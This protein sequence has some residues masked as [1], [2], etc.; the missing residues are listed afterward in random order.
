MK[1]LSL[2]AHFDGEQIRLDDPFPIE[3]D[4]PLIVTVWQKERVDDEEEALAL[5]AGSALVGA[6][7]EEPEY[8]LDLI[9]EPNP[10]YEVG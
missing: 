2:R 8:S 9:K 7:V 10:G 6:S 5:L 4:S 3:P 1:A